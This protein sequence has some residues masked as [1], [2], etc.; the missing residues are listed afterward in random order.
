MMKQILEMNFFLFALKFNQSA[1]V[2]WV[3]SVP[4]ES[5]WIANK[6]DRT[7]KDLGYEIYT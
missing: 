2:I 6:S 5:S 1:Y 7:G 3:N 4:L